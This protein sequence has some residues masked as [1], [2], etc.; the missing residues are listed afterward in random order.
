MMIMHALLAYLSTLSVQEFSY[1]FVTSS[2]L[3]L[4]AQTQ[5][6]YRVNQDKNKARAEA[7]V[8]FRGLAGGS[9]LV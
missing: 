9:F 1:S 5:A 8:D 4:I 3:N 2:W 6:P 7:V